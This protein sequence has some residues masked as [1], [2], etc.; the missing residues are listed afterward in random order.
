M[1]SNV[2]NSNWLRPILALCALA[3]LV[4][5]GDRAEYAFKHVLIRDVAYGM[6][7]KAVR[8]RKHFQ[9]GSFVEERAGGRVHEVLSDGSESEWGVVTA[10]DPAHRL[11]MDWRPNGTVR[12]YT[13][14]EVTFAPAPGARQLR[15]WSTS[16]LRATRA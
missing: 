12:P 8:A 6:L 7:P 2:M 10:W 5:L 1:A 16:R 4:A 13:E 11:V 14:V 3:G 9:V 15:V